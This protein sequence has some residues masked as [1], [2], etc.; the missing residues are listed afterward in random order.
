[1]PN[2]IYVAEVHTVNKA[3]KANLEPKVQ[4]FTFTHSRTHDQRVN[5]NFMTHT[6]EGLMVTPGHMTQVSKGCIK[7]Q[8]VNKHISGPMQS[9]N[10]YSSHLWTK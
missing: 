5:G 2:K 9:V 1:M 3:L 7:T 6:P 4:R 8:R 10:I